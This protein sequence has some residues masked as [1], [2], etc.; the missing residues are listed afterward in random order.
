MVNGKIY[1]GVH[2]TQNP[3]VFDGY[4]GNGIEIGYSLKNPS[5]AFQYALKKHGYKNFKRAT[6][7]VFDNEEQAYEKEAEIVTQDFIKRKDNYNVIPGGLHGGCIQKWIYQYDMDGNYIAEFYGVKRHAE[8]IGCNP[9]TLV[10]AC[11]EHR[12]YKNSY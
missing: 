5:T 9:M 2:K 6:L 1:I 8:E 7:F 12:S 3:D 11:A 4:L 10:M